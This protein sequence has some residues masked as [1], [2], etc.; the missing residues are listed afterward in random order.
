MAAQA[1]LEL[2]DEGPQ[3]EYVRVS[4]IRAKYGRSRSTV[5]RS[6][7]RTGIAGSPRGAAPGTA[8]C[9]LEAGAVIAVGTDAARAG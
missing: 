9:R 4:S 2:A 8:A 1:L 6:G 3:F 5:G 7:R